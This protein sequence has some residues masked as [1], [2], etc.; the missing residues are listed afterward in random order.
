VDAGNP[1]TTTIRIHYAGRAG[2]ISI[3]GA[4]PLSWTEGVATVEESPGVYVFRT[5]ALSRST[6]WKVLLDGAWSRGPN[7]HVDPGGTIDVSPHFL[8][9]NGEVVELIAT[10]HSDLLDNTRTVWAYL[11][12][13]YD[14]NTA[15]TY[16]VVYMH[17]GQNLFDASSAFGG[18]EW[19]VDETMASA[20]ELGRCPDQRSCTNDGECGG[21]RCD[22][23]H[24]AIVI[25]PENAGADRI[26]EYTPTAD[27]T[28]GGGGGDLYLR[29]LV[30]ELKPRVDSMLRTRTG[31]D[32]TAMIGSSLG[33][34]ISAYASVRRADVFGRIGA[35]SP[36]TWW[37][38]RMII[39]EAASIS[40]HSVRPFRVY[41]DSG[42]GGAAA[43]DWM[44]T[45]DLAAQYRSVG[46]VEGVDFH[47]VL[48]PGAEHNETAW[49]SRLPGALAF[50]LGPREER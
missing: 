5:D 37:D 35:M 18:V 43:D 42:N 48:Q 13:G 26:Y 45:A 21:A 12:P 27:S 17:D 36:S 9:S 15:A 10:F 39:A 19:R 40:S 38:G 50:L 46:Y 30:E 8:E 44:N 34:L 31:P 33:G 28:Y 47:Y 4:S 25:G 2:A 20:S 16:P 23:F 49:A 6:E 22:T 32:D 29:A 11:P 7:Y 24:E 1:S 41:V 3:R 14:E